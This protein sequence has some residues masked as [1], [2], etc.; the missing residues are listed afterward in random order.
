MNESGS[1]FFRSHPTTAFPAGGQKILASS[2]GH[3]P[4][5]CRADECRRKA[6]TSTCGKSAPMLLPAIAPPCQRSESGSIAS[7]QSAESSTCRYP[8]LR[9]SRSQF[10]RTRKPCPVHVESRKDSSSGSRRAQARQSL[11]T[12]RTTRV[13]SPLSTSTARVLFAPNAIVAKPHQPTILHESADKSG[14]AKSIPTLSPIRMRS[15]L[16]KSRCM[17]RV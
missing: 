13:D 4:G 6:D 15:A 1:R 10:H 17:E 2:P 12:H 16:V 3:L 8:M 9:V 7:S 14:P 5:H 11:L